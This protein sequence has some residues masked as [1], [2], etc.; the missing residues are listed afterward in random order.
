MFMIAMSFF[1]AG[2]FH[3]PDDGIKIVL[4]NRQEDGFS[5]PL[6]QYYFDPNFAA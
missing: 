6:I 2:V 3:V 5:L 4:I 1:C